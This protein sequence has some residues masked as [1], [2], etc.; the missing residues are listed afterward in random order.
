MDVRRPFAPRVGDGG[1]K[2]RVVARRDE[3]DRPAHERR[4][5][6]DFALERAIEILALEPVDA[7]READV[8]VRRVLVL[9]PAEALQDPWERHADALEEELPREERT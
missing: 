9:D 4:L 3:V 7:R 5:H 8:A 6:D 2:G 1:E